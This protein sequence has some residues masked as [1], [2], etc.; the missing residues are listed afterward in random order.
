[1]GLI[2]FAKEL[3]GLDKSRSNIRFAFEEFSGGCLQKEKKEVADVVRMLN[4][5]SV[6]AAY[7]K[8]VVMGVKSK[9][10]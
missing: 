7:S 4:Q 8:A 1:M 6:G 2:S 3:K 9:K 5:C 10:H